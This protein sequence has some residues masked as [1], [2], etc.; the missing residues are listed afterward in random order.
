MSIHNY[1]CSYLGKEV[2]VLAN[3]VDDAQR[4]AARI[5]KT[6]RHLLISTKRLE[7][8]ESKDGDSCISCSA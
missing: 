8:K 2:T 5:F 6:S 7:N 3:S 1:L 4:T